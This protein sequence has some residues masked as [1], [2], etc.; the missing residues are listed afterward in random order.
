MGARFACVYGV[1][2]PTPGIEAGECF[3]V[4]RKETAILGFTGRDGILFWFVFEH[5]GRT[6]H[7]SEVPRYTNA[8]IHDSCKPV[9]HLKISTDVT[10]QDVYDK[11]EITMEFVLEEGVAKVW[12]TKRTVIVGDAAHKMVPNTAM[13]ANQAMESFGLVNEL[14]RA[15]K[16]SPH[17]KP[18]SEALNLAWANGLTKKVPH[19]YSDS[20]QSCVEG[21]GTFSGNSLVGQLPQSRIPRTTEIQKRASMT[22]RAQLR[23]EGPAAVQPQELPTLTDA[24]WLFRGFMGLS[25]AQIFEGIPLSNQGVVLQRGNEQFQAKITRTEEWFLGVL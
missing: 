17:G 24:D 20:S 4:Y 5:L 19:P 1:F 7:L 9:G 23:H 12:H 10:F 18:T 11:R 25:D 6:V 2:P 21:C 16:Q 14:C 3:S 13:G 8:D 15:F 22:C